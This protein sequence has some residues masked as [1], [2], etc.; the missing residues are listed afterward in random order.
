MSFGDDPWGLYDE[1]EKVKEIIYQSDEPLT[2]HEIIGQMLRKRS[3]RRIEEILDELMEEGVVENG[4]PETDKGVMGL[5]N[6]EQTYQI[7]KP[8]QDH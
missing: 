5:V 2:V 6:Q 3:V 8:E 4:P 7:A 1:T